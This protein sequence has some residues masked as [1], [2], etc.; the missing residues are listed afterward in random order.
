MAGLRWTNTISVPT[1]VLQA[2]CVGGG[3]RLMVIGDFNVLS[4]CVAVGLKARLKATA[5]ATKSTFVDWD[6]AQSIAINRPLRALTRHAYRR[7]A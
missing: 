4:A 2:I 1:G 3:G 7:T 5:V 6:A